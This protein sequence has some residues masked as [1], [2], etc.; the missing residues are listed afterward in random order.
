VSS[1][2]ALGIGYAIVAAGGDVTFPFWIYVEGYRR[3]FGAEG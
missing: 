1:I 3:L 2:A